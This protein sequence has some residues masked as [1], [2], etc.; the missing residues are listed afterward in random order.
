MWQAHLFG[1]ANI[2]KIDEIINMIYENY[3]I[4]MF[5]CRMSL[6]NT[7]LTVETAYHAVSD[8]VMAI[9]Y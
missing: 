7:T 4:F 5:F 8:S 6:K 3:K 1:T 2:A 9:G